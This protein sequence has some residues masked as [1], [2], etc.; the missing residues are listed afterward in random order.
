M[1]F[2]KAAFAVW[3]TICVLVTGQM[4]AGPEIVV[5]IRYLKAEG[6]SHAQLFLYR[7]DGQF[8]RQLTSDNS[9]QM[10][11]PAFA[12]DGETIVFTR[13]SGSTKDFWSIEPRG[14]NL[15]SLPAAPAWYTT[16]ER[17]SFFTS[18]RWPGKRLGWDPKNR[19]CTPLNFSRAESLSIFRLSYITCSTPA[20]YTQYV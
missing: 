14:G 16:K 9:G 19:F 17:S 12:P 4:Y 15:R 13:E 5:A 18:I 7:Q 1:D 3:L 20:S 2:M 11:N 8:L 6:V 10:V